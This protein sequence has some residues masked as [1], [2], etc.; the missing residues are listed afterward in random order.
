M[1][2]MIIPIT[3]ISSICLLTACANNEK[4]KL[5]DS[6]DDIKVTVSVKPQG[7]K[8]STKEVTVDKDDSVMDALEEGFEVEDDNGFVTEID[9][10]Q[11]DPSK[12]LYW[13]Y[14]I[15]GKMAEKGAE[16]MIVSD[17]DKIVFYQEVA[18]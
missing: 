9:G 4:A 17:G 2:R 10:H 18:N 12:N 16:D 5:T 1:K 8:E 3:L 11:Q 6:S 13:M 7:E 14:D 15:N